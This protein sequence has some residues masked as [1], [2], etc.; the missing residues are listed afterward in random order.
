MTRQKDLLDFGK[1]FIEF[2]PFSKLM[3]QHGQG[4]QNTKENK[5]F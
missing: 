5:V 2:I 1:V 3:F 4:R